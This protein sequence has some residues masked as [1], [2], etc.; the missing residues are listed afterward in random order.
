MVLF[1][2]LQCLLVLDVFQFDVSCLWWWHCDCH[3]Q[4]PSGIQL[5]LDE[6]GSDELVSLGIDCL[7]RGV[8]ADEDDGLVQRLSCPILSRVLVGAVAHLVDLCSWQLG[9]GVLVDEEGLGSFGDVLKVL[10]L[11]V[12][13]GSILFRERVKELGCLAKVGSI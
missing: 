9:R 5:D 10:C 12:V 4:C 13:L 8:A 1:V 7:Y 11:V 3:W 6:S 2:G